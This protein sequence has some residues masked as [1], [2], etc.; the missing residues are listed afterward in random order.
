MV[1]VTPII[2]IIIIIITIMHFRLS[3]PLSTLYGNLEFRGTQSDKRRFNLT[4]NTRSIR[5]P[6]FSA[7]KIKIHNSIGWAIKLLSQYH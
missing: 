1:P 3:E 6:L 5:Q 2:I 4:Q 7:T